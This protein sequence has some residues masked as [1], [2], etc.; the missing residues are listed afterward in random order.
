MRKPTTCQW[1]KKGDKDEKFDFD[2]NKDDKIFDLLVQEKQ[3][4]LPVGHVFPSAEEIKKRRYCKWHNTY[5]HHTNECKIFRQQIQSTI[6]QGRIKFDEAKKPMKIEGHPYPVNMVRA[7]RADSGAYRTNKR[8]YQT[9]EGLIRK[10]SRRHEEQAQDCDDQD[11][12][13][14]PHW[15][16]EFFRFC[17]NEGMRLP[18]IRECPACNN[19]EESYQGS[20]SKQT[21][22]LVKQRKSVHKRLGPMHHDRRTDADEQPPN[23]QW[24]PD[25]IFTKIQKRWV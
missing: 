16:C 18:T 4:Q 3:I 10:Y 2:I 5:S 20:S 24:C 14:D 9:S 6:E 15:E 13:Y 23:P 21:H 1:V 19:I 25:D 17:W 7:D 22:R 12:S 11:K 8:P